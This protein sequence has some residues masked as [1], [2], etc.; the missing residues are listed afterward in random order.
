MNPNNSPGSPKGDVSSTAIPVA[1]WHAVKAGAWR[2]YGRW[3]VLLLLRAFFSKQ[4]FRPV[5][6]Y[7]L[8]H[9]SRGLPVGTR[10]LVGMCLRL[11]RRGITARRCMQPPLECQICPGLLLIHSYGLI[12]NGGARIGAN[13]T[14]LHQITIG[15]SAKGVP[16]LED[17]VAVGAGAV[18][19]GPVLLSKG[20]MVGA[21]A[22]VHRDVPAA[23]IV[24]GNPAQPVGM[25]APGRARNPA[26][27]HID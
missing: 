27:A 4:F 1:L 5:L 16:V 7:R 8:F 18:V 10:Q 19:I 20:C 6:T 25:V 13:C 9:A 23:T 12:V 17:G 11:C 24:A 15:G 22:M 14:F 2:L 26:P 21:A 3:S